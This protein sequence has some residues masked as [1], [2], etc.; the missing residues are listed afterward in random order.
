MRSNTTADGRGPAS[1]LACLRYRW[2]NDVASPPNYSPSCMQRPL[3][4]RH[5]LPDQSQGN[6]R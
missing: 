6:P 5:C 1:Q 2:F 4:T 3:P